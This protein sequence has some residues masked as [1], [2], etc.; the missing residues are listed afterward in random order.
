MAEQLVATER[1]VIT[2]QALYATLRAAWRSLI[3]SEPTREQLL[4]LMA[5]WAFETNNGGQSNNWNLAGIK[6][7]AGD[8]HDYANYPT[9]E[10]L[11]GEWVNLDA[12][13]RAYKTL[14]DAAADYLYELH[15]RFGFAWPAVENGDVQD[16]A[17]RLKLRGYYTAP[18]S[19]YSRGLLV[20]RHW[21][22]MQ[23]GPDTQPELATS[24]DDVLEVV[25]DERSIEGPLVGDGA[26]T[27]PPEPEKTS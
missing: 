14:E 11:N 26:E 4:V 12:D 21:I 3:G 18:E 8:G 2:P 22:D 27:P 17:H 1:T 23:L 9:R 24:A 6:H 5:Q 25:R 10:F 7:V 15:S 20:R 16:F 19:Q 13:F